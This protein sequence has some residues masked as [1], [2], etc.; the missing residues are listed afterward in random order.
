MIQMHGLVGKKMKT[1]KH[2][3]KKV[4][5]Y[6]HNSAKNVLAEWIKT[7]PELFGLKNVTSIRLEEQFC[8]NGIVIFQPD[9][10]VYEGS[11]LTK[12]YEICHKSP[13]TGLKLH[14]MWCYFYFNNQFPNVYEIDA[15]Y[16]M[17]KVKCPKSLNLIKY[18]MFENE[19]F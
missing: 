11:E 19:L 3:F 17:Q 2:H 7:N 8:E 10:C 18:G 12:I 4:E 14:K 1:V 9:V 13:L 15:T 16:I 5:S 6:L